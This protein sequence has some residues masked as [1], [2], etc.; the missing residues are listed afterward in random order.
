MHSLVGIERHRTG[1]RAGHDVTRYY[2][3]RDS[4]AKLVSDIQSLV[5]GS[6]VL[7]RNVRKS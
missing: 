4:S 5:D 1:Q 3:V 2:V 6:Y 7:R